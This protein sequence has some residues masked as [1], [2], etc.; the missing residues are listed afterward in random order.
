MTGPSALAQL[1]DAIVET[2]ATAA[3][4]V[5][6]VASHR[7]LS[8]GF[9]WREGLIVTA[10]EALAEEG[11]VAIEFADGS[12]H[13]VTIIGRDPSTD[14][15]LLRIDGVETR[16]AILSSEPPRAGALVVLAAAAES[17]PLVTIGSVMAVGEAWRS[18][19][20]GQIDA[21]IELDL[22]LRPRAEGGLVLGADG[23][24]IGMAVSGPRGRTLVIPT[25]TI[26][27][28]APLLLEHGEIARGYIGVGL[29]A[30]R[31]AGGGR[32]AMVMTVDTDGPAAAAGVL[33][34]DIILRWDGE[35]IRSVNRLV[36]TL[37]G[38]SVGRRIALT[39]RRAGEEIERIVA[40]GR[41]S[42]G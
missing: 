34:G 19:R 37:D 25:A 13:R 35:A 23:R 6:E 21:R 33:Q 36:R 31:L 5:V 15:A 18:M 16:P 40:V 17:A 41:R 39:L 9:V 27:R 42:R 38:E 24:A 12:Q 30:V 10:D 20:G 32:G 14:I 11:D 29:E 2:A 7:A 28:V 4:S 1:S 8:S 22:T 3:P 26:E